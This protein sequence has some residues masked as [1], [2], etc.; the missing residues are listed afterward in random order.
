MV[1]AN[2]YVGGLFYE[3]STGS[4]TSL[5]SVDWSHA[6]FTGRVNEFTLK[7]KTQDDYFNFRFDGFIFIENAGS[8]EFRTS[9]DD[10]SRL[11]LNEQLI[12]DN[13]G[14]HE[15]TTV[16]SATVPLEE[17]AQRIT[18]DFF[19]YT[20]TDTLI[21]E[22]KG[23]D[24]NNEWAKVNW[25]V[26]KSAEHVITGVGSDDG[27]EDSFVVNIFPNPTTQDNIQVQV[28]TVVNAPMRVSLLDP[29]GR[30]LFAEIF[31]PAD[32]AHGI[33]IITPGLVNTGIYIVVVEQGE[34]QVRQKVIIKR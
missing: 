16:T 26:L 1:K 6:E 10:A 8:Y 5:D 2:T 13:N 17:G 24:T 30:S 18:V 21:V 15:L 20:L 29:V 11:R 32:V 28:E 14:I 12:V 3:H 22:Y 33:R 25:E 27:P 4:W 34:M 19:E 7:P 9:S 23:A 31:Q